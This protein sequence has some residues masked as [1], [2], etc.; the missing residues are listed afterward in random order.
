[1]MRED[2]AT[3]LISFVPLSVHATKLPPSQCMRCPCFAFNTLTTNLTNSTCYF[4]FFKL[5]LE[6]LLKYEFNDIACM[7]YSPH[8]ISRTEHVPK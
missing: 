4:L 7:P 6:T 5:S 2:N 8:F 1:M 3:K